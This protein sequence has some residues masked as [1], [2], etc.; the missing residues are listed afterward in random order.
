MSIEL[1]ANKSAGRRYTVA[2]LVP[3]WRLKMRLKPISFRSDLVRERTEHMDRRLP[4]TSR[5]RGRPSKFGRPSQVVALTLPEEAIQ[6]L[7]KVHRDLGWAIVKLLDEGSPRAAA[8]EDD[9]QPEVEL[10]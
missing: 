1:S 3:K 2:A 8:R 9:V 10:V 4:E 6:R 7:R 5:R